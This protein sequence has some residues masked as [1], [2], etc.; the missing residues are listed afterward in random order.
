G[1]RRLRGRGARGTRPAPA[2]CPHRPPPC[3]AAGRPRGQAPAL[4]ARWQSVAPDCGCPCNRSQRN[5]RMNNTGIAC[6]GGMLLLALQATTGV[7]ANDRC[8]VGTWEPQGNAMADWM[9]R[10]NLP[11]AMSFRQ[12]TASLS[13]RADG[14]YSA[15]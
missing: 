6:L 4:M 9:K 14:S 12:E 2:P 8:L 13:F 5:Q 1:H 10:Q 11:M 3:A 15:D 7:Q